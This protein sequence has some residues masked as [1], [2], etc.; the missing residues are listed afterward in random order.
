MW[1]I[2]ACELKV[3]CRDLR[4]VTIMTSSSNEVSKLYVIVEYSLE[5]L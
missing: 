2:L 4:R 3:N 1:L 5:K